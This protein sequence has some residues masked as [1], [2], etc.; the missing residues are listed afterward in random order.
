MFTAVIFI[1]A[2]QNKAKTE[3]SEMFRPIFPSIA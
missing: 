2:K 1:I 3:A